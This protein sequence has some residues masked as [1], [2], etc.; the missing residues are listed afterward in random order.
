MC[1]TSYNKTY[2][3]DPSG[4]GPFRGHVTEDGKEYHL[5]FLGYTKGDCTGDNSVDGGDLAVLGGHWGMSGMTW[6]QGDF[7]GEGI[8]DGG[9]LALLGGNWNWQ[10]GVPPTPDTCE[11]CQQGKGLGGEG[12][13]KFDDGGLDLSDRDGDGDFDVDDMLII[14]EEM[15]K[16]PADDSKS[17]DPSPDE[18][19]PPPDP[20]LP[21]PWT[22]TQSR[23]GSLTL[24]L[25]A[26]VLDSP[27]FWPACWIG[28]IATLFR[29]RR[30]IR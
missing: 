12:G 2:P 3:N 27:L 11:L 14:I 20:N 13:G 18:I 22:D 8:V 23:G 1:D 17:V 10:S 19:A 6:S 26:A 9:D 30:R 16:P 29:P 25:S 21:P 5:T 4:Y 7:T 28:G 24:P 15:H